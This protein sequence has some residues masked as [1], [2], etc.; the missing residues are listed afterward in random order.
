MNRLALLSMVA[1][2]AIAAVAIGL[3]AAWGHDAAVGRAANEGSATISISAPSLAQPLNAPFEVQANLSSFT[4]G[5]STRWGGYDVEIAYDA[6]VL[7]V[8]ADTRGLCS[9][10]GWANTSLSPHVVTGCAFES[11]SGTGVLDTLTLT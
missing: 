9:A 5:Q 8:T 2:P 10:S 6:T 1:L 7:Q 3:A 4:P 11:Q